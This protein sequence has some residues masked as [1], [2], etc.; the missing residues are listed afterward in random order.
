[1]NTID[2]K[3]E[4]IHIVSYTN[5]NDI[6]DKPTDL[7]T[8]SYLDAKLSE[9]EQGGNNDVVIDTTNL[10]TVNDYQ[11]ITGQK[12][13]IGGLSVWGEDV[14]SRFLNSGSGIRNDCNVQSLGQIQC[15]V[16]YTQEEY[17][18]YQANGS[19]MDN[20]LYIIL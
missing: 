5:W 10:V 15:I 1:M 7:V 12:N 17:D 2:L 6:I 18:N 9:I 13:F 20:T 4:D 19:L 3:C 14:D 16:P 8:Y 11:D